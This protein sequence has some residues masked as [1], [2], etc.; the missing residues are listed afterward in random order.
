MIMAK[1]KDDEIVAVETEKTILS[2]V[3]NEGFHVECYNMLENPEVM[4]LNKMGYKK[5]NLNAL[6]N[7][8]EQ[9]DDSNILDVSKINEQK[10]QIIVVLRYFEYLCIATVKFDYIKEILHG[11]FSLADSLDMIKH[12][13]KNRLVREVRGTET[14]VEMHIEY[15]GYVRY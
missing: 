5:I 12:H 9:D 4:H 1:R 15:R 11:G 13:L 2:V 8:D 6:R 7:T 10:T 3:Y 14:I